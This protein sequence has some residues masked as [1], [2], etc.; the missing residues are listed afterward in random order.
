MMQKISVA[1]T[2]F[3]DFEPNELTRLLKVEPSETW[4]Q[5]QP[6]PPSRVAQPMSGW[7][8]CSD[9]PNEHSIE[10]HADALFKK[11]A[12]IWSELV[13]V[14]S[15]MEVELSCVSYSA[16]APEI[17]LSSFAIRKLAELSGSIDVDVYIY[18]E[19]AAG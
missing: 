5:G 11:L 18:G 12:P 1:L 13:R 10:V 7:R 19:Q 16:R 8:L 4:R 2:L 17:H 3:G 14:C 15:G 6:I 9:S